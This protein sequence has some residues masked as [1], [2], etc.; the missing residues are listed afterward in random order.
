MMLVELGLSVNAIKLLRNSTQLVRTCLVR[1]CLIQMADS[2]PAL[3][4]CS[5]NIHVLEPQCLCFQ[6]TENHLH[7]LSL[8]FLP[9]FLS[10]SPNFLCPKCCQV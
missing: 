3:I 5:I 10:L 7:S 4:L 2:S 9:S 8:S 1:I 6:F